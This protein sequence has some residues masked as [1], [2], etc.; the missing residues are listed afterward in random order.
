M[1]ETRRDLV[2]RLEWFA[3]EL[4]SNRGKAITVYGADPELARE[5]AAEI[6]RLRHAAAGLLGAFAAR[7]E[8]GMKNHPLWPHIEALSKAT[9]P[10]SEGE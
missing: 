2:E 9:F 3:M 5:A 10:K 1:T 4:E 7:H 8:G 6:R